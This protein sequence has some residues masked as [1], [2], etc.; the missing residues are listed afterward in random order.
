MVESDSE[1]NYDATGKKLEWEE[2]EKRR[3]LQRQKKI[4]EFALAGGFETL[5]K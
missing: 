2:I 4:E 3:N 5:L 1:E